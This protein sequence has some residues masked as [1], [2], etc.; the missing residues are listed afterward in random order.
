MNSASELMPSREER[1]SRAP[2]ESQSARIEAQDRV[3]QEYTLNDIRILN[4][5]SAF[6]P[7]A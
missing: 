5:I 4:M 6:L 7:L 3:I 2:M 1:M